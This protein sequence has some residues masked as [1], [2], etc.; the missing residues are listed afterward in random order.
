MKDVPKPI[1]RRWPDNSNRL[2]EVRVR[3]S[4]FTG[5]VAW[6]KHY[7]VDIE[8]EHNEII[9]ES[10][11]MML[12]TQQPWDD[13]EGKGRKFDSKF[14]STSAA[15]NYA[16]R[17]FKKHFNDGKH[18]MVADWETSGALDKIPEEFRHYMYARDGD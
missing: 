16:L 14:V 1:V 12:K 2:R 15:K 6:A 5:S 7:F 8:E 4:T 17:I 10:T 11:P 18:V 9:I 3:L 13:E